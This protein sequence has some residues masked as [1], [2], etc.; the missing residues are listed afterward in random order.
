MLLQSHVGA[1]RL[2]PALPPH[3]KRGSVRGLRAR[4]GYTVDISWD[5]KDYL[6]RVTPRHHGVIRLS[7]GREADCK[8]GQRI[9]ITKH[10]IRM[11]DKEK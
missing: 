10:T 6:A 7:D 5:E 1:L 3:W 8:R 9:L 11:E 2:L 4:G